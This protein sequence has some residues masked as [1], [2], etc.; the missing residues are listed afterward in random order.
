MEYDILK[1]WET[2]DPWQKEY[3]ESEGNC[4][5]LTGRQSGKST[6]MS[7]KAAHIPDSHISTCDKCGSRQFLGVDC[8]TCQLIKAK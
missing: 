1:P 5:L 8:H 7:I 4:F 3:I 6:A 2:L